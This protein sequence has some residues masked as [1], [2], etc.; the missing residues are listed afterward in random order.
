MSKILAKVGN[1]SIT[2]SDVDATIKALGP[3][4]ASYNTPDGRKAVL[5]QIVAK[6]LFL[7]EAR[8]NSYEKDARFIEDLAKVKDEMLANF[9]IEK[10]ISEITVSDDEVKKYYDEHQ[11]E[12]SFPETVTASHILVAEEDKI[13]EI[14]ADITAGKM[15]FEEAAK[16]FSTCPSGQQGGSLGEFG[17]GQMVREFE[18]AAF[19]MNIGE[20]SAPV[21]TQFGYHL[22]KLQ[23]K[24][25]S[26]TLPFEKV[27]AELRNVVLQDKQQAAYASKLNQLK[28]VYPVDMY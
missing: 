21:K 16:K 13:K 20:V 8:A 22:I 26:G 9:A 1:V 15:S 23:A 19:S 11:S 18:D 2:E 25:E 5:E 4:G 27:E 12:F 14:A 17:R 6:N 10:T 24:K 7:N 28:I 3:R